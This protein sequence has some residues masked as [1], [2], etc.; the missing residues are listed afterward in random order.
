MIAMRVSRF[1]LLCLMIFAAGACCKETEPM[2]N[3]DGYGRIILTLD[4]RNASLSLESKASDLQEGNAF[5]S[6]LVIL[7]NSSCEVVDT[8]DRT[9]AADSTHVTL[10]FDNL[11]PGNYHVYAYANY[12]ATD[13]QQTGISSQEKTVAVGDSFSPYLDRELAPLT[14]AGTDVPANPA[15]A[16]LLTGDMEVP[17][18]LSTVPCSLDLIRPVVR[19]KVTVYNH[20]PYPVKVK[21]LRFSSFNPDRAFLIPHRTAEGLPEL[22]SGA[23]YRQL[24]A[25]PAGTLEKVAAGNEKAVYDTLLYESAYPGTHKIF[26]TLM[27]DRSSASLDSLQISLGARDFGVIDYATLSAMDDGEQV[28]VLLVNPQINVR[29]GRILAYISPENNL[30]W[31]SA[32]YENFEAFLARA[33]AIYNEDADYDYSSRYNPASYDN[34]R[35]FSGWDGLSASSGSTANHFDYTGA[36]NTYFHTLAKS[37]GVFSLSGLARQTG[38]TNNNNL[39]ESTIALSDLIIEE[40]APYKKGSDWKNPSD[41]TGGKLVRFRRNNTTEYVYADC[42]FSNNNER[43]TI[44]KST[45]NNQ[46]SGDRQFMLFGKYCS[47]G[48]LKRILKENNKEVPLTY[49]AR[50][51]EVNVIINVYYADQTGSLDFSV[52]NSTWS[53]ATTPTHTFK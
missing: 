2:E 17:V 5:R 48:L 51:E 13:W 35:G 16:M 46:T 9:Y 41:L 1:I 3:P 14:A 8:I 7:T 28:D 39:G 37:A 10:S 26:A 20:T 34:S 31:E 33:T 29:S 21:E 36:R 25:Y 11:R 32:G 42:L 50:N 45:N 43:R 6:I 15:S 24:P 19:F 4:S 23:R 27:L 44:I 30:A 40:G 52:D 49:L 47:G 22:P 53:T 12:T 38:G 18:G